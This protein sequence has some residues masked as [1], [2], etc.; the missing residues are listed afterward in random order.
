VDIFLKGR[1]MIM[2]D[3]DKV[4]DVLAG[5]Q[6]YLNRIILDWET[7]GQ[8]DGGNQTGLSVDVECAS[9]VGG[10]S[11]DRL[12]SCCL[13]LSCKLPGGKTIL[14]VN[15]LGNLR[16][17]S[18]SL[19]HIGEEGDKLP[20]VIT[21]GKLCGSPIFSVTTAWTSDLKELFIQFSN[22]WSLIVWTHH[23]DMLSNKKQDY[24]LMMPQA[25]TVKERALCV[26]EIKTAKEE[27][28]RCKQKAHAADQKIK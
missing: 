20:A 24:H 11:F 18:A 25:T 28:E 22:H 7:S 1:D 14:L 15:L 21:T 17:A 16:P 3:Q 27:I 5:M 6:A 9:I 13:E 19:Q 8:G 26:D 2:A 10:W 23:I 4:K 12:L